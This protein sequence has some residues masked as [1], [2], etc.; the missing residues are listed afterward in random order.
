MHGFYLSRKTTQRKAEIAFLC[1]VRGNLCPITAPLP[2]IAV[3]PGDLGLSIGR[4]FEGPC[5]LYNTWNPVQL[6]CVILLPERSRPLASLH[7]VVDFNLKTFQRICQAHVNSLR[8][9][10]AAEKGVAFSLVSWHGISLLL[11]FPLEASLQRV[12]GGGGLR[13][14]NT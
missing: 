2:P 3:F 1:F 13:S 9:E 4:A 10:H 14:P 11:E 12:P 5:C 6:C 8:T 7:D